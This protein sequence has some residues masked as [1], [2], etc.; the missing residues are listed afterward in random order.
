MK[1][2]AVRIWQIRINT[3]GSGRKS[4]TVRW[5]VDG[6]PHTKTFGKRPLA[7]SFRSRLMQSANG[8]E[9][10]DVDS[11]L[12]ASLLPEPVSESCLAFAQRYIAMK[13][14]R[15]A[16]K[17]RDALSD[18]L[19][20]LLPS[21]TVDLPGRPPLLVVRDVLRRYA[22]MPDRADRV[23]PADLV[24]PLRW[25]ETA[26]RPLSDLRDAAI[27]RHGLDALA[28][29]LDGAAAAAT[30][31]QRKRTV[32]YNLLQYAVELELF[33]ANPLDRVRVSVNRKKVL[34]AVDRRVVANPRQVDELLVACSY[35]G[36]RGRHGTRGERLVAF[37][38]CLYYAGLRPEEALGL[39]ESGCH[40]PDEGWGSV[41]L[42]DSRPAAGKRWT[43]S[44]EAH[45]RRGLK[46]RPERDIRTV[47]IPPVLVAIL[48]AHIE[49]FGVADDGRLFRSERGNPVGASTY[50]RV[51]QA[52]R[53][54][55]LTPAQV[56]SPLAGTPYDL[57]HGGLSL[58]LNAGLSAPEVARRA[59][60]SVEV[61]LAVY[62][63]CLDDDEAD[64]NSR[65]DAA[66]HRLTHRG[67]R[68][69]ARSVR[70]AVQR[71]AGR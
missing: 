3:L 23:L 32:F 12:P 62:A 27:V 55:A 34:T 61:L 15:A 11:G 65:I 20:T 64:M 17:T 25:L 51:W 71:R 1:S 59:G 6:K 19:S 36:Q 33:D 7:D 29:K 10:F 24:E 48:R 28:V 41:T 43:D 13:W 68:H 26:S 5:S 30:T 54:L 53:T 66:L 52:A 58:W 18:G 8:G 39:V 47:P 4:Y 50:S 69:G 14:P 46:H 57:R 49:R 35:V 37:F 21:L 2:H 45:D 38:G 63:K 31:V 56:A 70:R 9:P 42:T 22:L 16:A 67:T 44:G 40:L 60:N